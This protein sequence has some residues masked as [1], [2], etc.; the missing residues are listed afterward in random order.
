MSFA[1]SSQSRVEKLFAGRYVL[2]R[3]LGRG[4]MGAVYAAFDGEALRRVALKRIEARPGQNG[5]M[6]AQRFRREIRALGASRHPGTP[7]LLHCDSY[8]GTPYYTMEIV[9]GERLSDLLKGGPLAPVRAIGLAIDLGH[10]LASMHDAGVVHRDVKPSNVLIEPGDRVRLIDFGACAF[11][12]HFFMRDD[13]EPDR[14][15]ATYQRWA[16]GDFDVVHTPGYSAP[17]VRDHEEEA[18]V[19]ND[20][21]SVC[22]IVYEMITG[23]GL[24]DRQSVAFR[25]IVREEFAPELAPLAAVLA[26]GAAY[27][28][29]DRQ[30]S[31]A[32]LVQALEVVRTQVLR[33]RSATPSW[34]QPVKTAAM[35]ASAVA[36]MVLAAIRGD[37]ASATSEATSAPTCAPALREATAEPGRPPPPETAVPGEPHPPAAPAVSDEA[38][39]SALVGPPRPPVRTASADWRRLVASRAAV[40]QRCVDEEGGIFRDL[41]VVVTVD[42]GRVARVDLV[43]LDAPLLAHCVD[44]RLRGMRLPGA[45]DGRFSHS[46]AV[47]QPRKGA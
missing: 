31:M 29:I 3:E 39:E 25:G 46:F 43:D 36:V 35:M 28:A 45:P 23:R 13:L 47:R 30:K 27:D 6:L 40:L 20:I 1:M 26:S 19:R 37:I 16:T 15:T 12:P 44:G 34:S 18:S 7:R 17:E 9:A 14:L 38:D 32:E 22:A 5:E 42:A 10:I 4:G 33:A 41:P 21:F 24:L 2:L 8:D 11:L